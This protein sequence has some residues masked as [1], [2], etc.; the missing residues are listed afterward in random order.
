M[1][2]LFFDHYAKDSYYNMAFDDWLLQRSIEYES[3]FFLRL[4][5]WSPGGIT[6]GVNQN[7]HKA[8]EFDNLNKTPVIRRIT[9]G[10]AIYHDESELTYSLVVK[11]NQISDSRYLNIL[12]TDI[13]KAL[14]LFLKEVDIGSEFV[15]KSSRSNAIKGFFHKAPCFDS[16]A[17]YEITSNSQ[18]IIASAQRKFGNVIL[19]HGSIKINGI[20][21]HPA[22]DI[23]TNNSI[24][25]QQVTDVEFRIAAS[26]MQKAFEKQFSLCYLPQIMRPELNNKIII[27]AEKLS[28]NPFLKRK[29][30]KQ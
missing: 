30:I 7:E 5:S 16:F 1:N 28:E 18:K 21:K 27:L 8:I 6:I 10:R 9:G 4:Y 15:K 24:D 17:K 12:N 2:Y 11:N 14:M 29:I 26:E 22:I 25:Y 13:T 20:V 3:C 23:A 19:Q